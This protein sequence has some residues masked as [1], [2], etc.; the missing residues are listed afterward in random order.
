MTSIEIDWAGVDG[1]R[2]RMR[3]EDRGVEGWTRVEMRHNGTEWVATGH[4][5]VSDVDLTAD[6]EVGLDA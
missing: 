6:A 3:F 5:I 2:R 4:E 1:V